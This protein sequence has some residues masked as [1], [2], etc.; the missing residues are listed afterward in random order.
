MLDAKYFRE[1]LDNT[2]EALAKR[3][4]DLDVAKLSKLEEQRKEVQV[5]TEQL[6]AER[7]SRSKAIGKAKA[8]GEDI[9]PLLDAVS[10]LGDQLD[11]AKEELKAIQEELNDIIM[12]VPNLPAEEVPQGKDESE[13]QEVLTWGEPKSFDFEVKDH[14]DLGEALAKGM[15]FEAAAKL[16]GARFVVMR[17]GIARLHRA[18]TQFML[19]LHTQEH[20]YLE[21]YVPY[22]VNQDSLLGTGQ[23][24]KFGKDLFH[25][26]GESQD[27]IPMSLIPTA[28]VP[29]TN[30]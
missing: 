12:G 5:R 15:D 2:A 8:A 20:G 1:E 30:L 16:T 10:D 17:G 28:E 25:I 19:D 21:T 14:V 22:M 7:N 9:Q 4:F 13:N 29:L 27:Q 26:E 24:P 3:G 23:L 11:S 6:Q 18:L